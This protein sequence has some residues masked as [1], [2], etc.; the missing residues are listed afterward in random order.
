[1]EQK[2]RFKFLPWPGLNLGPWHLAAAAIATRLPRTPPFSRLLRHAGSYSRT[3]LTPNL[4][5]FIHHIQR[6]KYIL[7]YMHAFIHKTSLPPISNRPQTMGKWY[8]F[9]PDIS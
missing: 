1:M 9:I 4:Q 7:A 8:S 6:Y 2:T 5:G 3:I